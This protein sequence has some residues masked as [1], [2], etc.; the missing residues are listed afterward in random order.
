MSPTSWEAHLLKPP[1][2][3]PWY[4]HYRSRTGPGLKPKPTMDQVRLRLGD[5]DSAFL[6]PLER[7]HETMRSTWLKC[8]AHSGL[9]ADPGS[10]ISYQGRCFAPCVGWGAG[11]GQE[12][13]V[14]TW[15]MRAE[16]H[17]K[18]SQASRRPTRAANESHGPIT[19]A[20]ESDALV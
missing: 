11:E 3:F 2:P 14:P 13:H 9:P 16:N 18:T 20:N 10:L 15:P 12:S 17:L 8:P 4:G 1:S 6:R 19:E 7:V 5:S